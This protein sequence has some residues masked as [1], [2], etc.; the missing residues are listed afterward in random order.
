MLNLAHHKTL[1][2][3]ESLKAYDLA[4][5][6]ARLASD[7]AASDSFVSTSGPGQVVSVAT[8]LETATDELFIPYTEGQKYLER[9]SK[10]LAELY[11]NLLQKF[12]RYHVSKAYGTQCIFFSHFRGRN[13]FPRAKVV[14]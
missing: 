13:L 11:S 7:R 14:I 5:V 1:A 8:M 2:L 3:V 10:S 9:E 12:N 4:H 6:T